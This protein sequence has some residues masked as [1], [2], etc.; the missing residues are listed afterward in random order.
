M[1]FLK[2]IFV[3][4]LGL[5]SAAYL[6]N[7]GAGVFGEIPDN[8]PIIGNIDEAVA[9]LLLLHCLAYFGLDLRSKLP[10]QPRS[11]TTNLPPP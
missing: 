5:F 4:L 6:A 2:N 10:L 11:K 8:L 7:V 9:T 1:R 3:L